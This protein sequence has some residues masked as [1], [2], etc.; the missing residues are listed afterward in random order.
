MKRFLALAAAVLTSTALLA[1]CHTETPKLNPD[2]P[3]V[4]SMWH[5]YG[6]QSDSPM[7]RL[8]AEF[9]ETTGL[10]KGVII[11]VTAISNSSAVDQK[12]RD[13]Q[14]GVVGAG[15]FPDLFFCHSNSAAALGPDNL[16]NWKDWFSPREQE[17]FV[18]EF[19]ADGM[20][21]D[22]LSVLPV[23]KSTHVLIFNGSQFQRFSAD[24]GVSKDDLATWDG[25]FDA[26]EEFHRWSG[27]KPFCAI[28]FL[29]RAVELNAASQGT[30]VQMADGWYDFSDPALRASWMEFARPLVQG[31][32]IVSDLFS[33][34]QVMT[35]EVEA[36]LGS[37]AAILYYNDTVTYE[38]N[39][40]EPMKL[41]TLP[42]PAAEGGT[43]MATQSGVGLCAAKTTPEKAQAAA[44]FAHWL[45]EGDR[46]L[47][48]VAQTGY[49]PVNNE[50]FA[51]I[52]DYPFLDEDYANLYQTL[53]TIRDTA[54]VL[55]EPNMT[56][57]YEKVNTLYTELRKQQGDWARRRAQ[58]ADVAALMEESWQLF[59]SIQ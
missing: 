25:F 43:P 54:S 40:T 27:G 48:F 18:P 5:V 29:L 31:H 28:D 8:V 59:S 19:L 55:T 15:Q 58:G 34:T 42:M 49:M 47:D 12:L 13:A 32:I 38:D 44:L 53:S 30:P 46:N 57:Y 14:A 20:V 3:V 36:G 7:N 24:T 50:S 4:L 33:N 56:G 6:E 21:G 45:T 17:A 35:G 22:S 1:G 37:S 41:F 10:E 51:A 52:Q 39:S 2:D 16:L 9:N 23:S 26:A 11:N